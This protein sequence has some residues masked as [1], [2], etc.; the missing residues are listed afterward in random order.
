MLKFKLRGNRSFDPSQL[1]FL[2]YRFDWSQL[3]SKTKLGKPANLSRILGVTWIWQQQILVVWSKSTFTQNPDQKVN[4]G[5]EIFGWFLSN[6]RFVHS[7]TSTPFTEKSFTN[8]VLRLLSNL[9]KLPTRGQVDE[10]C[11][12]V[13]VNYCFVWCGFFSF[14]VSSF[15]IVFFLSK[16]FFVVFIPHLSPFP[17]RSSEIVD[18]SIA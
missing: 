9:P 7:Q 8:S 4:F 14:L 2:N 3:W 18:I 12:C 5:L 11:V 6:D 17:C 10:L 15:S 1:Y 13:C 16:F